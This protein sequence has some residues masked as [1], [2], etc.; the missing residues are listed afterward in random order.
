MKE[1]YFVGDDASAL[2]DTK[3]ERDAQLL[4]EEI[5]R[6]SVIMVGSRQIT[7]RTL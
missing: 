1:T 4:D 5:I 3:F 6:N 2:L 7:V